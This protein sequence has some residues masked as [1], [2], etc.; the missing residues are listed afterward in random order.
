MA[1]HGSVISFWVLVPPQGGMPRGGDG[2]R[3]PVPE[4]SLAHPPE[5]GGS[6]G[7]GTGI[8]T[9]RSGNG[10]LNEAI[11]VQRARSRQQNPNPAAATSAATK[12]IPGSKQELERDLAR[13]GMSQG[14][15]DGRAEP[16]AHA[17][18]RAHAGLGLY[19]AL[20]FG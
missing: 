1:S 14:C 11:P 9:D 8:C 16:G 2:A 12:L 4:P 5:V 13:A 19:T 18:A 6:S 3:F 7:A 15:G 10:F 17:P 20:L